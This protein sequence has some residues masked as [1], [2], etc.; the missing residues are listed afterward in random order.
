MTRMTIWLLPVAALCLAATP[1]MAQSTDSKEAVTR[2]M[3]DFV[4]G[5]RE[6]D[7]Q[8]L[9]RVLALDEGRITWVSGQGSDESVGSMTFRAAVE[10]DRK[11][12]DNGSE[13][14]QIFSLD[15]VNDELAVAKL[16][17]PEGDAVNIDYMVCYRVAGEW[18][19]VSNTFVIQRN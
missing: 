15:V 13:G 1:S 17:I 16:Q 12:P 18:R 14:W 7:A 8:L 6:G 5:W 11:H 4:R 2:L 3:E 9:S 19:I 10:R